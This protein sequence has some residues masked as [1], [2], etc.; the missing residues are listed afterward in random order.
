M[1]SLI[2]SSLLNFRRADGLSLIEIL[3]SIVIAS[4]LSGVVL[5]V[6]IM[7]AKSFK[8]TDAISDV[9]TEADIMISSV[10]SDITT[11]GYDFIQLSSDGQTLS[12]YDATPLN[13][14]PDSGLL[15]RVNDQ[16]LVM[17][18]DPIKVLRFGEGALT[19]D[20]DEDELI[21]VG[22]QNA[23]QFQIKNAKSVIINNVTYYQHGI[24]EISL[25]IQSTKEDKL[26]SL[27]SGIGF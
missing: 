14:N 24:L 22:D 4:I 2:R 6:F 18:P 17:N 27:Q 9:R 26:L 10:L 16:N 1:K 21:L 12:L 7:G 5:T 19:L 23:S 15:V 11:S 8:E 13:V 25:K 20:G 3:V